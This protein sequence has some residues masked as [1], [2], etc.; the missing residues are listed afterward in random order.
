SSITIS[1]KYEWDRIFHESRGPGPRQDDACIR[2]VLHVD[3]CD[4]EG[5]GN[6]I[7]Q[8]RSIPRNVLVLALVN[9]RCMSVFWGLGAAE[10]VREARLFPMNVLRKDVAPNAP[11]GAKGD[12]KNLVVGGC[13]LHC[14]LK[15][16]G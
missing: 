6:I 9:R 16:A 13:E 14:H 4:H 7:G 1:R 11:L 2:S 10:R 8:R 15:D 12:E 3:M 5:A